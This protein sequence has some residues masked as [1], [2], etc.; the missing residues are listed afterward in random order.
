MGLDSIEILMKVEKTFGINI[1]DKEAEK[2]ITVSDFHNSVWRHLEGKYS[3]KCKSQIIF[4][5]LRQSFVEILKFPKNEFKLDTSVNNIFRT[6]NR[7]QTY[8]S[9]AS[10]TNLK[11]PDLILTKFWA[12]FLN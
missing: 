2:I 11:L 1:P 12:T 3:D 7:R 9:F 8:F 10:T 4:Y 5:K 6:E